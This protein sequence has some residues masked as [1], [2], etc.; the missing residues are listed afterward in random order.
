M[1]VNI[2]DVFLTYFMQDGKYVEGDVSVSPNSAQ[3]CRSNEK[4]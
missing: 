4:A 1:F 3:S 2:S